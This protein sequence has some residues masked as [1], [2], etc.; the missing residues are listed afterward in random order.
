MKSDK[1]KQ[2]KKTKQKNKTKKAYATPKIV[3]YGNIKKLTLSV[4]RKLSGK[5]DG[6]SF[7]A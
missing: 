3:S 5:S 6:P 7:L 4:D 2:N 1:N